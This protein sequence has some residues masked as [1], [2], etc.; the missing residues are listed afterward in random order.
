M[1][2]VLSSINM[3]LAPLTYMWRMHACSKT[4][5]LA[6]IHC[7]PCPRQSLRVADLVTFRRCDFLIKELLANLGQVTFL[8]LLVFQHPADDFFDDI[9]FLAFQTIRLATQLGS[10]LHCHLARLLQVH[11]S[12]L[13]QASDNIVSLELGNRSNK[14]P[15]QFCIRRII[16][17]MVR[18]SCRDGA[19]AHVA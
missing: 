4:L 9:T 2:P 1:M 12:S 19:E 17:E 16:L 18:I 6:L 5:H 13:L 7:C 15:H 8:D 3:S 14:L 11:V 10:A